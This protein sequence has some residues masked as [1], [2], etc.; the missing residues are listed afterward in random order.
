MPLRTTRSARVLCSAASGVC[1]VA[2]HAGPRVV[3]TRLRAASICQ[4]YFRF[5]WNPYVNRLLSTV[6]IPLDNGRLWTSRWQDARPIRKSLGGGHVFVPH[7]CSS[8]TGLFVVFIR[9]LPRASVVNT[10]RKFLRRGRTPPSRLAV[11]HGVVF[12][13]ITRR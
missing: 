7:E 12:V 9:L 13:A 5:R 4:Q 2:R 8:Y 3:L 11:S 10:A 1:C 6:R